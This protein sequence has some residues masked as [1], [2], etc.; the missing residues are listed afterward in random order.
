LTGIY[1]FHYEKIKSILS[2]GVPSF[3][4]S[5]LAG[6]VAGSVSIHKFNQCLVYFPCVKGNLASLL[7]RILDPTLLD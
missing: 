3:G 7:Q 2:P 6:A 4:V 5:F 1:W